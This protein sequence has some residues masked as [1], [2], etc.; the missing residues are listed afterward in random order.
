MA[1]DKETATNAAQSSEDNQDY[2]DLFDGKLSMENE[3]LDDL[4]EEEPENP[5]RMERRQSGNIERQGL[6]HF[7]P[8]QVGSQEK[9]FQF[10][11]LLDEKLHHI[12][13]VPF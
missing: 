12:F 9:S 10:R 5:R 7:G 1:A 13:F 6:S 4:L 8:R 2:N 11:T 3:S